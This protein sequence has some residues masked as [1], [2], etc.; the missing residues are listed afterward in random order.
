[1]TSVRSVVVRASRVAYN[2]VVDIRFG[3]F[4]A[5]EIP[6]R[7]TALGANETANS[8]YLALDRILAD[9]VSP[10]DVLVDVGCG[11]G[12]VINWW[13]R[14]GL[15]NRIVGIELDDAVASRTRKRLSRYPNVT[16]VTGHAVEKL[17]E[18]GTIFYL[19]NPFT[20]EVMAAF[21]SR[22]AE[23]ARE[24]GRV[25]I[26]YNNCKDVRLFV[27]DAEWDV[28]VIDVGGSPVAQYGKAAF[29]RYH[30]TPRDMSS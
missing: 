7:Y 9:P 27:E 3:G 23:L 1:M 5:G 29:I 21:K 10:D 14:R 2:A 12:R 22:L 25:R 16:I 24:R 20:T 15:T 4:L 11:K 30:G 26:I 17:P 6:S 19:F 13:L 28:D 8:D 18:D